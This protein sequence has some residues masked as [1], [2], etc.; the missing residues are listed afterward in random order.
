MAKKKQRFTP[1][2]LKKQKEF[3]KAFKEARKKLELSQE[4]VAEIT[5]MTVTT[6][7]MAERGK[8][9][10]TLQNFNNIVVALKIDPATL[11]FS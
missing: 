4:Q 1:E 10:L 6:Y 5:G 11:P 7:A 2:E 9:N 3:G 8:A